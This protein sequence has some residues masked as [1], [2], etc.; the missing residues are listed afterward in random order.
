MKVPTISRPD[1]EFSLVIGKNIKDAPDE[2][3]A[4]TPET[5][6]SA[7]DPPFFIQH[8]TKD[9]IGPYLQSIHLAEALAGVIGKEKV[10][11][12]LLLN[13]GHGGM[14]FF[15]PKNLQKVFAFLDK[16]IKN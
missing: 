14:E 3:K 4:F 7:D 2:V 13:A 5:Y 1:S 6:I 16:Y 15:Q 11:L 12:E 10:T 9:I 8:G